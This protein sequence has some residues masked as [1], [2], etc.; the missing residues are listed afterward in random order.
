MEFI[1]DKP[2]FTQCDVN[3]G[4]STNTTR[5]ASDILDFVYISILPESFANYTVHSEATDFVRKVAQAPLCQLLFDGKSWGT[6]MD[7]VQTNFSYV[8]SICV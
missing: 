3:A 8:V 6:F 2:V 7:V 1:N 5:Y 4:K